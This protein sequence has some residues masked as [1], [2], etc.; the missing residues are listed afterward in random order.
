MSAW[1]VT[2]KGPHSFQ[3]DL[4]AAMTIRAAPERVFPLL[5]PVMEAKWIPGWKAEVIHSQSGLA[6]LGCIFRTWDEDGAERLWVVTRHEAQAG[7]IDFV[8][9]QAGRFVIRLEI[10]LTAEGRETRAVWRYLVRSLGS[11]EAIWTEAYTEEAFR[12]RMA[13][14]EA[15]LNGYLEA[16]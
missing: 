1:E 3:A 6:E 15:L 16:C 5:C 7:R 10:Q 13:R 2:M 14:L 11:D 4:E 8:Q 9:I 12:A